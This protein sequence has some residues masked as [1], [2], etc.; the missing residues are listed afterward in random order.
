M[1]SK[2]DDVAGLDL[3]H[4]LKVGA[5][6]PDHLIAREPVPCPRRRD[7]MAWACAGAVMAP[8]P[9]TDGRRSATADAPPPAVALFERPDIPL[10]QRDQLHR[11]RCSRPRTPS[12]GPTRRPRSRRTRRR[13][14]ASSARLHRPLARS[15]CRTRS[16]RGHGRTRLPSRGS[17][18]L[19]RQLG[20]RPGDRRCEIVFCE[21]REE[22]D[23]RRHEAYHA[24]NV[25]AA[26]LEVGER[27]VSISRQFLGAVPT[28]GCAHREARSGPA[29]RAGTR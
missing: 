4:R 25:Q 18:P 14:R 12:T 2:R 6:R 13:R 22:G 28:P 19:R 11:R 9:R 17:G 7:P 23:R 15:R 3:Q 20:G 24:K 8:A 21:T 29:S 5:E 1:V 16:H 10:E 27:T 26:P